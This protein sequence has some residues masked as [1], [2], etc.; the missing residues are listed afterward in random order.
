MSIKLMPF[1]QKSKMGSQRRIHCF[2][3]EIPLVHGSCPENVHLQSF[4]K[5]TLNIKTIPLWCCFQRIAFVYYHFCTYCI[6]VLIY[7]CISIFVYSYVCICVYV[8]VAVALCVIPCKR[9]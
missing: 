6:C 3:M 4:I 7:L 2:A 1:S 9:Q 8:V 5:G